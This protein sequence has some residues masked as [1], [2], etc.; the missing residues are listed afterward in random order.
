MLEPLLLKQL[1]FIGSFRTDG[2][3]PASW[4]QLSTVGV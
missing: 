4:R 3:L 2:V 1:T